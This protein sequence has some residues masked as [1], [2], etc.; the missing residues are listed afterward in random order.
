MSKNSKSRFWRKLQVFVK[1]NALALLICTTT[2]LTVGV[3]ALS[4]YFSIN[5]AKTDVPVSNI[6]DTPSQPVASTDPVV[7]VDPLDNVNI[8]KNYADDHLLKDETTGIWQTHQAIDFAGSDVSQ[9]KAV[10]SG[11]IEKIENSMMDGTVITLKITDKLKVVYK[12]LASDT[13][14]SEGDKVKAG[15][16]IGKTGTSVTEKKQGVHLHLEVYEN[17]KL[18][19]P[20]KYFSFGDK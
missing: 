17:G 18:I 14:V 12:S 19:D 4:A 3:I 20:N 11:V 6:P 10:Y 7:F 8:I 13:Q 1:R 9:V 5:G 15:D 16:I 2:V